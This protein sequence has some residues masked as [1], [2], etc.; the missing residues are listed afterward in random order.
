MIP[1]MGLVNPV[2]GASRIPWSLMLI[3]PQFE[4]LS[5]LN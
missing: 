5:V 3:L 4:F 1:P 2:S